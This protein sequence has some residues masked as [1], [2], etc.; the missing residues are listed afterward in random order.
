MAQR[1][2]DARRQAIMNEAKRLFAIQGYDATSVAEIVSDLNMPVGSVYTY[3][4][5]KKHL[6]ITILEEGWEEFRQQLDGALT[7]APDPASALN[8]ILERFL[9]ALFSDADF[10]TLSLNE[11]GRSYTLADKL[12]WLSEHIGVH[13]RKLA[14]ERNINLE[15]DSQRAN[16]ALSVVF[17]GSLHT[18]RLSRQ[19]DLNLTTDD[20]LDFIRLAIQNVFGPLW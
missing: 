18:I 19:E 15:F 11:A 1:K 13:I 2:D 16:T 10:I 3:F 12:E 14:L 5:D 9:P 8:L 6:L 20:V 17:L 4:K 7:Q